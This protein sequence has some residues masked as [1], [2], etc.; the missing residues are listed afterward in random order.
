MLMLVCLLEFANASFT[1]VSRNDGLA[2]DVPTSSNVFLALTETL[3]DR[4]SAIT[5]AEKKLMG[6][7]SL[8]FSGS[9]RLDSYRCEKELSRISGG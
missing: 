7:I 9:S 8:Y 2:L 4:R 5:G 6:S 3:L 1:L